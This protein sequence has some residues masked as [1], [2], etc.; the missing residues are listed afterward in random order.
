M[1]GVH[2]EVF[3]SRRRMGINPKNIVP[4]EKKSN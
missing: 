4:S 1:V 2:D 3:C